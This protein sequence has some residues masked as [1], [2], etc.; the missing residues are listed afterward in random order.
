[1]S[2]GHAS[3]D[4]Q[5]HDLVAPYY[6]ELVN[7][8]RKV[9]S[10]RIFG[11]IA[12]LLP[13]SGRGRMLDLGAGTGQ[14]TVRLGSR[15]REVVLVD[16]SEGM[17]R[18]ARENT[19]RMPQTVTIIQ[20]DALKFLECTDRRFDLIAA[21]GFLHHLESP[22][23]RAVLAH[24]RRLLSPGGQV[25]IAEP[26]QITAS[27]P[28]LVRA[29]NRPTI[30]K[31]RKYVD[32]APAPEEEFLHL[33]RFRAAAMAAGYSFQFERRAWEL[34]A[35]FRGSLIDRFGIALIDTICHSNGFVWFAL[36]KGSG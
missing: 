17:L 23:L 34:Y 31:L 26:V 18:R 10:D 7:E 21:V 9:L 1:M 35:R 20:A 24:M 2:E 27:E 25:V 12:S 36:M 32:L 33:D 3:Q 19:T 29:W 8:P 30:P 13:A 11:R 15:Y 4:R 16:H 6:D 5:H 28:F 14:M 22:E